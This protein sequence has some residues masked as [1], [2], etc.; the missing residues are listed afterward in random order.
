MIL[1]G[2]LAADPSLGNPMKTDD[3]FEIVTRRLRMVERMVWWVGRVESRDWSKHTQTVWTDGKDRMFEYPRVP[4]AQFSADCNEQQATRRC[5][6]SGP[7]NGW[8]H[9]RGSEFFARDEVALNPEATPLWD[10][11]RG[12][13]GTFAWLRMAGEPDDAIQALFW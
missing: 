11:P 2:C 9:P 5:N 10:G 8:R 4:V 1:W 6:A 13:A 3:L 12:L 7:M